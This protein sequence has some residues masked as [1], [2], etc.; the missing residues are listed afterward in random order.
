[1]QQHNKLSRLSLGFSWALKF[2]NKNLVND[3]FSLIRIA[4]NNKYLNL[5]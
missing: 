4:D 5:Y 2:I 1:M 3:N